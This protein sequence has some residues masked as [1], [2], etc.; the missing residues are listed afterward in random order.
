M[1][2]AKPGRS[3]HKVSFA[4]D[5]S[6]IDISSDWVQAVMERPAPPPVAA[7]DAVVAGVVEEVAVA[8]EAGALFSVPVAEN[9]T[10]EE[11]AT[12]EVVATVADNATVE[13]N[14]T[15]ADNSTGA[16]FGDSYGATVE[17][18][19]T[20]SEGFVCDS[21][22]V[23]VEEN[24]TV[25]ITATVA[26][27]ATVA[28]AAGSTVRTLR[29]R[30]IHRITD[31]LTPGQYSVYRLMLEKGD[32]HPDGEG[33]RL[34]R[35]GYV[36]LVNLTGLSKRGIQNVVSELQEKEVIGIHQAPG[37]HKSQMTVYEVAGEELV[38]AG[39]FGKGWRYAV[40]KSKNLVKI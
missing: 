27:N 25:E 9:A 30:P 2:S 40:G 38:L 39:W 16:L 29:L 32:E 37:Y 1:A 7:A 33:K 4:V 15:V 31:G 21:G 10:V 13:K 26:H 35:G 24:A 28:E 22:P 11:V 17:N 12:V 3:R 20:V 8:V 19:A 18:N 34:F 5:R 14:A 23:T 6:E 36:D